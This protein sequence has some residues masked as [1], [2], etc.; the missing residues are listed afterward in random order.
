M[1]ATD[2]VDNSRLRIGVLLI[3]GTAAG[4]VAGSLI[5]GV[6]VIGNR[7]AMSPAQCVRFVLWH[8]LFSVF[9]A[10]PAAFAVG[11]A[12]RV[13]WR[14]ASEALVAAF[15][16][17]AAVQVMFLL[18]MEWRQ[19][20]WTV[21]IA[22]LVA[23]RVARLYEAHH[24][25]QILIRGLAVPAATSVIV[26]IIAATGVVPSHRIGMLAVVGFLALLVYGAQWAAA[27]RPAVVL[28]PLLIALVAAQWFGGI[29]SGSWEGQELAQARLEDGGTTPPSPNV[30]LIVLDTTR[31]DHV[32][33]YGHP[34]GLTPA[35]DALAAEGVLYSQMISPASWTVPS[36]AS[37]FTGYYPM[38]HGCGS[39]YHR[40]LD[41]DYVALAEMLSDQGYQTVAMVANSWLHR[42]RANMLQGVSSYLML[43]RSAAG[44]RRTTAYPLFSKMGVPTRWSDKGAADSVVALAGW[45]EDSRDSKRPFYLFVNLME[46]HQPYLPPM[47]WRNRHLPAG[48]GYLHASR[49]GVRFSG[50]KWLAGE[51]HTE[52]EAEIIRSLYAAAM[53]YQD[54]QLGAIL[55][56]LRSSIDMNNTLL[57]IT[58]DHGENLGERGLWDHD[59]A[60]NDALVHVPFV[61][62]YPS[63]FPAGTR[64]DG[65]CQLVDVVPTVFDVLG[66]PCPTAE[67]PGRTLVP[68]RFDPYDYTYAQRYP[69]Y[70]SLRLISTV[71]GFRRD[72]TGFLGFLRMIRSDRYKYV[73]SSRGDHRLYDL[74]HDPREEANLIEHEPEVAADL[75]ARL[76]TWWTTQQEYVPDE[77]QVSDPLDNLSIESLRALGYM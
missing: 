34:G 32:G 66:R 4:A 17:G 28:G 70:S 58:S 47:A 59:F 51:N 21:P 38:T 18:I 16:W 25:H 13:L 49:V 75:D 55:E 46:A 37:L 20:F 12:C 63:M 39:E 35:L 54:H 50:T 14:R 40:W 6:D 53:A 62:R 7:V 5:A 22:W 56:V 41:D 52:Q 71:T 2:H 31:A 61:I 45:L 26:S 77:E 24:G 10:L 29:P 27:K 42:R 9:V 11:L 1:T 76:K 74:L 57:I 23:F 19:V 64:V 65:Q 73:W 69:Q 33:C 72:V 68:E 60:V 67:L 36:H 48:T 44:Q 43:D 15:L 30:V 3:S 8:S